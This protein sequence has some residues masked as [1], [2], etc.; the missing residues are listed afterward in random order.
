MADPSLNTNSTFTSNCNPLK[1]E[2]GEKSIIILRSRRPVTDIPNVEEA[3]SK[4]KELIFTLEK[5]EGWLMSAMRNYKGFWQ[6][7][8]VLP[9]IMAMEDDF[10]CRPDDVIVAS[11]LKS[12]T[13]W[14]KALTFTIMHRNK[15]ANFLSHPLLKLNP[16]DCVPF[17]EYH[18]ATRDEQYL[19]TLPCPR[20]LGTHLPYSILPESIKKS[21]CPII[22]ISREPKDVLVSLWHMM[23]KSQGFN[24][25]FTFTRAFELFCEGQMPFGPV[26]DHVL[27][28][29]MKSLQ[30]NPNCEKRLILFLKY[31]EM[32]NDPVNGVMKL[33][34]FIGCPFQ[35]EEIRNGIVDEI[36]DFCSFNKLKDLDINKNGGIG[37]DN[38]QNDF[39]F[40]KA[41]VGDWQNHMTPEMA[42]K[43]D[44]ITK[45]KLHK[46]GFT[47]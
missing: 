5:G 4:Y 39:F 40:R 33:A 10:Q 32:M 42:I 28:Y 44:E 1:N 41:V 3:D 34:N 36:V 17:T 2:V 14:L 47:Y 18:Y 27:E 20:V 15:Y 43:L 37:I 45:Q 35:A 26:W 38:A 9:G 7:E 8:R 19:E 30:L 31:E 12:G 11:Y 22:Y 6:E 21:K 23:N 13:T 24:K 25:S 29:Y 16:H 46:S